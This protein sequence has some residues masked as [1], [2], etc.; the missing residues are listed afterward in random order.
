MCVLQA[1]AAVGTA[2]VA[3]PMTSLAIASTAASGYVGYREAE[4]AQRFAAESFALQS[5]AEN[6]RALDQAS[7]QRTNEQL[8]QKEI[9]EERQQTA[10]RAME[11]RSKF[12]AASN[13]RQG[14][15]GISADIL[16]NNIVAQSA[17]NIMN[18][19]RQSQ[20]LTYGSQLTIADIMTGS[21]QRR[22]AM[23]PSMQ[24]PSA[25]GSFV[26]TLS[27][28]SEVYG[29]VSNNPMDQRWQQSNYYKDLFNR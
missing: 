15:Q 19:D 21:A 22:Q 6:K 4:N 26:T 5:E 17:L 25:L 11:A 1:L 10:I 14:G 13:E 18:L 27:K 2:V 28:T 23:E 29:K 3:N 8:Q 12:L 24:A 7:A 9:A 16:G 20:D